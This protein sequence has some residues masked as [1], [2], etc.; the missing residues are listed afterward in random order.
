MSEKL[1]LMIVSDTLPD[2]LVNTTVRRAEQVRYGSEGVF[3]P[4]N[5]L[6]EQY[7]SEIQK[8]YQEYPETENAITAPDGNIYALPYINDCFHC[9]YSQRAWIN[10]EWLDVLGLDMPST[11]E[12]FEMVMQ[13]FKDKDP[14]GN[15]KADEIPATGYIGGTYTSPINFLSCA[16]LLNP[17]AYAT[18]QKNLYLDENKQVHFAG[19]EEE[20]RQALIWMRGLM[21]KGLLDPACL[22]QSQDQAKQLVQNPEGAQVGVF[23]CGAVSNLT[24]LYGATENHVIT[25]YAPLPPLEGPNG[26]VGTPSN[27]LQAIVEGEFLISADCENPEAAFR[28]WDG[29]YKED[30]TINAWQGFEGEGW[31][32]PA[33]GAVGLDG[34][35]A[36]YDLIVVPNESTEQLR[37]VPNMLGKMTRELR[38]GLVTDTSTEEGRYELEYILNEAAKNIYQPY[39]KVEMTLPELYWLADEAE[40]FTRL[41]TQIKE[42]LDEQTAMFLLGNRNLEDDW[43]AYLA[44][45]ENL[46]LEK[47]LEMIQTAYDR[48][49]QS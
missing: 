25:Q 17:D 28:W 21:E 24:G 32:A 42:Y 8:V 37:T 43:D 35:P 34:D 40:E 6:I 44:E 26:F 39:S 29:L 38:A 36:L 41:N 49:Y 2:M 12:E 48:Q 18:A 7:G 9:C 47:M 14:N 11:T 20:Y 3:L 33:E 10:Q 19:A 27:P 15:G 1:N 30:V 46:G 45:L 23:F 16:F 5:S 22:T 4:L 13:E 31:N